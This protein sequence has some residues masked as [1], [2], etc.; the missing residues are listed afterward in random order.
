M[1]MWSRGMD[2]VKQVRH[3]VRQSLFPH[4]R[5]SELDEELQFHGEQAA[6]LNLASGMSLSEARRQAL[7]EFGGVERTREQ[8]HQA[9]PGWWLGTVAEDVRYAVR[10]FG[11]NPVFTIAV[12]TGLRARPR[13]A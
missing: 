9:R 7:V 4:R 8:C 11:R 3:F 13:T 5:Q 12:N 6:E 1:S 2:G 10:G